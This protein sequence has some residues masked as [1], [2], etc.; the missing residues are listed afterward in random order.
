MHT[1]RVYRYR[2]AGEGERRER[3]GEIAGERGSERRREFLEKT[4]FPWVL[5]NMTDNENR[6][7]LAEVKVTHIIEF[8]GRKIGLASTTEI[9]TYMQVGL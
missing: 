6:R 5:T 7:P 1:D 3:E 9:H 4:L 2:V 8:W